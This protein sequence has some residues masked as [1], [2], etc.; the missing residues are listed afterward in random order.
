[1]L[2]NKVKLP[3][4]FPR[5]IH[6][7]RPR[8]IDFREI[9]NAILYLVRADCAGSGYY[10]MIFPNGRRSIITSGSWQK[11]GVGRLAS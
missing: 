8:K 9:T 4:Y 3:V 10:L 7:G 1:M 5:Q 11:E 2:N 6:R